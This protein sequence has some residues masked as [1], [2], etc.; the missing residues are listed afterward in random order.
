MGGRPN[1][2]WYSCESG[3]G[4]RVAGICVRRR[5]CC[6]A[7]RAIR[8]TPGP[9]PFDATRGDDDGRLI[10]LPACASSMSGTDETVDS[11]WSSFGAWIFKSTVKVADP[12]TN[13]GDVV[14]K[15]WCPYILQADGRRNSLRPQPSSCELT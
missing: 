7:T 5:R 10:F 15:C 12:A 6:S 11:V 8:A 2:I 1:P 4:E 9:K 3:G 13:E 14:S